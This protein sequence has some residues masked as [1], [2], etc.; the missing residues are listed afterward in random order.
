MSA[1]IDKKLLNEAEGKL[2]KGGM[3][4]AAGKLNPVAAAADAFNNIVNKF[5][6]YKKIQEEQ[7]TKRAEIEARRVVAIEAIRS[8]KEVVMF[9][10]TNIFKER[11]AALEKMFEALDKGIE[12]N[13]ANIINAA[14]GGIVGVIQKCPFESF[15]DFNAKLSAGG[16]TL[17]LG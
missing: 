17:D 3:A 9:A 11:G 5:A 8:Q 14:L 7:I 4:K 12:N 6:E 13:D 1:G 10:L 2:A 15:N 16:H